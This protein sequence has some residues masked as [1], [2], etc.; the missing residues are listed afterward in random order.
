MSKRSL[1]VLLAGVNLVLLAT[2]ILRSWNPPAAYAQ[3]VPLGANYLMVAAEIRDGTDALYVLDLSQR[4][5]H[6]YVPNND[7]VNRRLF[8]RGYRDLEQDFR[9]GGGR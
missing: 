8:H 6:V 9:G 1:V 4:R 5:L 3:A 2:L 7:M